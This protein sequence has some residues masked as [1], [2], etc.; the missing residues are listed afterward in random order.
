MHYAITDIEIQM[1]NTKSIRKEAVFDMIIPKDALV[2]NFFMVINGKTYQGKVK[3]KEVAEKLFSA[4]QVT[5]GLVESTT[6]SKFID[7]N[8][9]ELQIISYIFD[10][11][12]DSNSPLTNCIK[13]FL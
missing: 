12:I 4:S 3:T 9:V 7:G 5:S 2:S 11:L 8:Q 6:Q 13:F 1:Q 10:Y